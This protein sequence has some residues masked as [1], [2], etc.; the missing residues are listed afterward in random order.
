MSTVNSFAKYNTKDRSIKTM[1]LEIQNLQTKLFKL[2]SRDGRCS[3]EVPNVFIEQKRD[4]EVTIDTDQLVLALNVEQNKRFLFASLIYG[5][6]GNGHYG[7]AL[8]DRQQRTF[9]IYDPSY[10]ALET[11]GI[12][13][14]LV[15]AIENSTNYR[16]ISIPCPMDFQHETRDYYCSLWTMMIILETCNSNIGITEIVERLFEL[17]PA[18]LEKEISGFIYYLHDKVVE[19]GLLDESRKIEAFISKLIADKDIDKSIKQ[20]FLFDIKFSDE[21]GRFVDALDL[22]D[23]TSV[24]VPKILW[25]NSL[26]QAKIDPAILKFIQSLDKPMDLKVYQAGVDNVYLSKT[27]DEKYLPMI[28]EVTMSK[29][30]PETE[31]FIPLIRDISSTIKFD[32]SR[33]KINRQMMVLQD[34]FCTFYDIPQDPNIR[35]WQFISEFYIRYLLLDT[36]DIRDNT[37]IMEYRIDL[38][39]SKLGKLRIPTED[40]R[41]LLPCL[42]Y[43]PIRY[44]DTDDFILS[45]DYPS[46]TPG[47]IR[48]FLE[49]SMI[50]SP[51]SDRIFTQRIV[52][53]LDTIRNPR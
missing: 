32:Y 12:I 53:L 45:V 37:D 2:L 44:I 20:R 7:G 33:D 35:L 22:Y 26:V 24:E 46:T 27:R 25:I 16:Y 1:Y 31:R 38:Y 29:S 18:D 15:D 48:A 50:K 8:F 23:L 10:G 19:Y 4:T 36:Y 13:T 14:Y 34:R 49:A 11:R 21:P 52:A 30:Y 42:L 39:S 17:S 41:L 51:T 47:I 5:I 3:T 40:Q 28:L 6:F 9:T 43:S